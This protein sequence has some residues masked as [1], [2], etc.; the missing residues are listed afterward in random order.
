MT[1]MPKY[2]ASRTIRSAD[3][4]NTRFL[5][6]DPAAE[7]ADLKQQPGGHLVVFGSGELL[8][9]L[10][11]NDLIDEYHLLTFPIV[12]G[13]GKRL[14]PELAAPLRLRHTDTAVTT[15]GVVI[16]SYATDDQE[17]DGAR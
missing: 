16:N 7:I 5:G 15:T 11:D 3:W 12:L 2:V 13:T 1:R 17:A 9:T 4:A 8:R 6:S 14:F 10:I